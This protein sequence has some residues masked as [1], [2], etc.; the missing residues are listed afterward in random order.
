MRFLS[1]FSGIGGLDLGLERA[2]MRCVGQ[3]EIDPYCRAVLAKHWPDVPRVPDITRCNFER[4]DNTVI[5]RYS[6]QTNL[7]ETEMPLTDTAR[8]QK[9]SETQ[10]DECVRMYERGMSFE[11]IGEYWGVSRQSLWMAFKRR[12]IKRRPQKREGADNHFHRGGKVFDKNAENLVQKAV[13]R[14]ALIRKPCESCGSEDC[15]HGHHD[16][17]NKPLDV[18]WLCQKCH[19]EWH[20]HNRAK[21]REVQMDIGPVD[22]IVGGVPKSVPTSKLRRKK[23][24]GRR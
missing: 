3:V 23:T 1:L 8:W 21:G 11:D 4:V 24:G 19:F 18:R 2:G 10:F 16:D 5:L 17:Y 9:L 12:G 7:G 14:G 13:K 6:P 20:K 22:L 15:V